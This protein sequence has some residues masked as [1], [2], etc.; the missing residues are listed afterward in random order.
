MLQFC[1]LVMLCNY[2]GPVHV[3]H[4]GRETLL[5]L[6]SNYKI[7]SLY[8]DA[9]SFGF[10]LFNHLVQC[11]GGG[12]LWWFIASSSAV[13]SS[14]A[15]SGHF[16]TLS[17]LKLWILCMT[18][19]FYVHAYWKCTTV[20]MHFR[21]QTIWLPLYL[22]KGLKPQ[23]A[24]NL[25]FVN[26]QN[27]LAHILLYD[28]ISLFWYRL[29]IYKHKSTKMKCMYIARLCQTWIHACAYGTDVVRL[30]ICSSFI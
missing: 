26:E 16:L 15:C 12:A 10:D 4:S 21:F 27:I 9:G 8:Q 18:H 2:T 6:Y 23:N 19:C 30:N 11:R 5:L 24:N 17:P 28:N 25:L 29:I 7:I 3:P 22:Q 20:Y 14:S 13:V 1:S